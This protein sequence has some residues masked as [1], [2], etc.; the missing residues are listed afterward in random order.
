MKRLA[1]VAVM[2]ILALTQ[3]ACALPFDLPFALPFGLSSAT[4]SPQPSPTEGREASPTGERGREGSATATPARTPTFSP[5]GAA[6]AIPPTALR[7]SATPTRVPST[8]GGLET[9][10]TTG[11]R[12]TEKD[13]F[14]SLTVPAGW[15]TSVKGERAQFC[16]DDA[17]LT[18]L[19]VTLRIKAVYP[20][21]VLEDALL[22]IESNTQAFAE[23]DRVDITLSGFDGLRSTI[24]YRINQRDVKAEVYAINR[25]RVGFELMTWQPFPGSSSTQ[26]L[27]EQMLASFTVTDFKDAPD[28]ETWDEYL[29]ENLVFYTLPGTYAGQNIKQIAAAHEQAYVAIQ[30]ALGLDYFEPIFYYLYPNDSAFFNSTYRA[31]GFAIDDY[32]EVHVKWF[33]ASDHQTVGHEMTHVIARGVL[34][35]P[36]QAL[37]GEGLA[38]CL[39][40]DK[41]DY[42][43]LGK[44]LV[45]NGKYVPLAKMLGDAWFALDPAVTYP[46]SGAFACYLLSQHGQEVTW[47][48]YISED[49][50]EAAQAD[51]GMDLAALEKAFKAWLS[52]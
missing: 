28:Y 46:Q 18:C 26:A 8:P 31:S 1:L 42:R 39:D 7:A 41:K 19:S 30:Q 16:A 3:F 51:L 22:T 34:G 48:F 9:R 32:G 5:S 36:G 25:N 21:Q 14:Y 47:D 27:F 38:A 4:T 20:Q 10:P 37:M 40:Q 11:G 17:A 2:L 29:S 49:L 44:A 6:T 13:G 35:P 33:S 12:V 23:L 15:K 43:L 50:N 45:N 24:R 52:K